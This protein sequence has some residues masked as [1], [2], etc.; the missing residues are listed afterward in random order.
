M[1]VDESVFCRCQLCDAD[2]AE[3]RDRRARV[4]SAGV[5]SSTEGG[6]NST[7]CITHVALARHSGVGRHGIYRDLGNAEAQKVD[8]SF[9]PPMHE[10]S[11]LGDFCT[12]PFGWVT[13]LP[14]KLP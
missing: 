14:S 6:I 12:F 11:A 8:T 5:D 10:E 7:R 9:V 1:Q 3:S 13:Q 4:M 2:A